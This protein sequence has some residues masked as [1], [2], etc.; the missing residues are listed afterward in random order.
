MHEF[1]AVC[2]GR[3]V[4]VELCKVFSIVQEGAEDER[5]RDGHVCRSGAKT[6]LLIDFK[7]VSNIIVG[8]SDFVN[9]I[10]SSFN[11]GKKFSVKLLV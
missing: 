1:C 5:L 6:F 3:L 7:I 4:D 8:G 10:S 9:I 11:L 2:L